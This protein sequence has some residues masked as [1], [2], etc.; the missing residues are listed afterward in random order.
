MTKDKFRKYL[1][2]YIPFKLFI[3]Y[4]LPMAFIAGLKVKRIDDEGCQITVKH[5]WL[6]QNP[7]KSMYFAVQS[8]AAEMSTG[9]PLVVETR[10][11]KPSVSTLVLSNRASFSKKAVGLITF[12][13]TQGL[14]V[15]AA[16]NKAKETAEPVTIELKSVGTDEAGDEVAEFYF[17]WTLR[18]K[19][20]RS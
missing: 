9:M 5:S 19:P 14:E 2:K 4:S 13:C 8:M 6:N 20:K 16:V 11:L 18:V 3:L 15:I 7:F 1:R 10:Y 17:T 12:S